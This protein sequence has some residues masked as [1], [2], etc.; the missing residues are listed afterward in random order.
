MSGGR[1]AGGKQ[2][3]LRSCSIGL[4]RSRLCQRARGRQPC[5]QVFGLTQR[6]H[7]FSVGWLME[8]L[9]GQSSYT[10]CSV[11]AYMKINGCDM[12]SPS[13]GLCQGCQLSATLFGLFLHGLHYHLQVSAPDAGIKIQHKRL[14]NMECADDVFLLACCPSHLQAVITALADYCQELHM[15]DS[16]AKHSKGTSP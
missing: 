10:D 5:G 11:A 16:T 9:L 12:H 6:R 3:P 14:T 4:E 7:M 1:Q 2:A 8:L 13:V 15:Q